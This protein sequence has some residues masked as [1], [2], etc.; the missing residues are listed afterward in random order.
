ML[1][2]Q[3]IKGSDAASAKRGMNIEE[4]Q[5]EHPDFFYYL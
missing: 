1:K 5:D 4:I 3:R 2:V